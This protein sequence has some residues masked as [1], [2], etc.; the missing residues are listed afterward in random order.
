MHIVFHSSRARGDWSLRRKQHETAVAE[1]IDRAA[2]KYEIKLYK[3]AI[4]GNHVHLL[5]RARSR[6]DLQR[7]LRVV[8]GQIAQRVTRARRGRPCEEGF[9]D[10]IVYT[11]VLTWGRQYRRVYAYIEMNLQETKG[12]I[13]FRARPG[14]QVHNR[15][16][17]A[18]RVPRASA[19]S[20]PPM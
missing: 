6:K 2:A 12:L 13:A 8:G 7:F 17:A 10:E 5:A 1:I 14:W 15:A 19:V 3:S 4:A 11:H 18:E 20:L 9:W 16:G